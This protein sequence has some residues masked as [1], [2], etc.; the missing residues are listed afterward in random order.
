M[1]DKKFYKNKKVLVTGHTGFKGTWLVKL[2]KIL[3]ADVC[4]YALAP[5]NKENLYNLSNVDMHIKSIIGDI[6]C[7]ESLKKV[8]DDFQPEI[9]I[10]LAA[11]PLVIEGY[12][13]PKYT[14]ETNVL[15]ALNVVECVRQTPSV[16]SYL[17]VTTEKVY[18]N[19]ENPLVKISEEFPLDGYD[20]YSNS[21]S[22]SELVTQSYRRSFFENCECAISTARTSNVIGGGDFAEN[23]IMPD[24][25]KAAIKKESVVVRSANSLRPYQYILEP[26]VLYLEICEK[27]YKNKKLEG[28]YN[29]CPDNAIKT[30]DLVECFCNKWGDS[31]NWISKEDSLLHEATL[32]QVSNAKIKKVFNWKSIY[33]LEDIVDKT[34]DWTKS[35]LDSPNNVP[36]IMDNQIKEFLEKYHIAY[37]IN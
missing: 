29:I 22:C 11:Q 32:L 4:G 26:L 14:F 31:M 9:V 24:C 35:Y 12:L 1:L 28:A 23:R 10:H 6:R 27:Q 15:G 13:N 7:Y 8:F 16:K 17:N 5:E 20:P 2:L 3:E 37:F 25:I 18:I 19:N 33:S 36:I 30:K 34:I 21:K